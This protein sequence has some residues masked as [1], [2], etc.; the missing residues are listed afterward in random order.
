MLFLF[1]VDFHF[2]EIHRKNNFPL[3]ICCVG[4][5]FSYLGIARNL[6][7]FF[8]LNPETLKNVLISS[9]NERSFFLNFNL[10]FVFSEFFFFFFFVLRMFRNFHAHIFHELPVLAF[11]RKYNTR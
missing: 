6:F 5:F 1:E 9:Q 4:F 8:P 2:L 7:I 3:L 10:T 11:N